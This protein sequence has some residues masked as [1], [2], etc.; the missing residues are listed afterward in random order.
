MK[1]AI[2]DTT[3]D[4]VLSEPMDG[5]ADDGFTEAVI[6]QMK[7]NRKRRY[8]IICAAGIAATVLFL[9]FFPFYLLVPGNGEMDWSTMVMIGTAMLMPLV[10]LFLIADT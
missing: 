9:F 4:A 3:L 5:V 8:L 1:H 2:D 10:S 6:E 7:M